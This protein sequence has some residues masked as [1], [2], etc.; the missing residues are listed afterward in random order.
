MIRMVLAVLAAGSLAACQVAPP[1]AAEPKSNSPASESEHLYVPP[2]P[3]A[4]ALAS[5]PTHTTPEPADEATLGQ[6]TAQLLPQPV[7]LKKASF[8]VVVPLASSPD[9]SVQDDST[10]THI[11]YRVMV[12]EG[13]E[14]EATELAVTV[15]TVLNHADGWRQAGYTFEHVSDDEDITVLLAHPD[16]ID[17]LCLPMKTGG[18]LSCAAKRRA[19]LNHWRWT[20]GAET[21]GDDVKGYRSY[22][23]NHEVGHL[24]GMRHMKCPKPGAPA[25]VMLPQTKYLARCAP[26]GIPTP[27]EHVILKRWKHRL[28]DR[29]KKHR[30]A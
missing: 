14:K 16:T 28:A 24:L 19:H 23:I 30:D 20:D 10:A 27:S 18:V 5:S 21:W 3:V 25:P 11:R 8:R 15:D 2:K 6:P 26:N 1:V 12:E 7:E 17:R 4:A 9:R 29:L 13:L 22:L